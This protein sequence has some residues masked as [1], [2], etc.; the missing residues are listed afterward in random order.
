MHMQD[1][2]LS[3]LLHASSK[4]EKIALESNINIECKPTQQDVMNLPLSYEFNVSIQLD[5]AQNDINRRIS[6]LQ[7]DIEQLALSHGCNIQT[8]PKGITNISVF[9]DSRCPP[10]S[11]V[12]VLR[13][14]KNRGHSVAVGSYCKGGVRSPISQAV[15][16][17]VEDNLAVIQPRK[18]H[19]TVLSI[20]WEQRD[21]ADCL[22]YGDAFGGVPMLG[23]IVL[24]HCLCAELSVDIAKVA[25][26]LE[27]LNDDLLY[28]RNTKGAI[29]L[30]TKKLVD[31]IGTHDDASAVLSAFAISALLQTGCYAKIDGVVKAKI[32]SVLKECGVGVDELIGAML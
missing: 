17:F 28:R 8:A 21:I 16:T 11:L 19:R 22:G 12:L 24:L 4:V 3:R 6:N 20:I 15:S 13:L 23:E 18:T 14:L 32:D 31:V 25:A 26:H 29:A 10:L 9:A 5:S 2:I 7:R 30:L 27:V 1:N